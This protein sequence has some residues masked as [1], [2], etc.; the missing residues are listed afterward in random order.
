VKSPLRTSMVRACSLAGASVGGNFSTLAVIGNFDGVFVGGDRQNLPPPV[1]Y[2]IRLGE[3]AMAADVHAV[4]LVL[5]GTGNAADLIDLL[6]TRSAVIRP[7]RTS[8]SA[9]VRPAGPAPIMATTGFI[10]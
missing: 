1:H 2:P 4:A 9:A 8:S 7:S 10:G 6:R 5:D 3:E